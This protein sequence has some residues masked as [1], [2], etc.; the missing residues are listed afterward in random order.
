L[1]SYLETALFRD[2]TFGDS[3][4]WLRFT[5]R[6]ERF[7]AWLLADV[8]VVLEQV[9]AASKRGLYVTGFLTFE[10]GA[11][12][13]R[14]YPGS[15]A[16]EQGLP[17]CRFDVFRQCTSLDTREVLQASE[18]ESEIG[19]LIGGNQSG[20]SGTASGWSPVLARS[21]YLA[22]VRQIR[23]EIAV[24]SV[25]QV[26]LTFPGTG[27]EC[28]LVE[29]FGRLEHRQSAPYAAVIDH[30]DVQICSASPE[31][32]FTL[33]GDRIRCRPMK[34]TARRVPD[35]P[36]AD[37][38]AAEHLRINEKDRAENLMIVDMV[39]NDLGRIARRGSVTVDE[40][41]QIESFPTVH[42]M[43]T[44]VSAETDS[45]LVEI[46][47]AL[48]PS[49]S[50][51]G[52]PK[53]T[54]LDAI[55][56]L[57]RA[58]R[59]IYTGALGFVLPGR[60]AQFNVAIRTAFRRSP[61]E[62]WRYDVGSGV[63]WDSVPER[64]YQECLTKALVLAPQGTSD[65][66]KSGAEKSDAEKSDGGRHGEWN[67]DEPCGESFSLLESLSFDGNEYWL[68][69]RHLA[70]LEGAASRFG[71]DLHL[72]EVQDA[73]DRQARR[74][75]HKR[76]E[77]QAGCFKVRLLVARDGSVTLE[78]S[79]ARS[80]ALTPDDEGLVW[81]VPIAERPTDGDTVCDRP[82]L[83]NKTTR[84]AVYVQ[85]LAAARARYPDCDD[86]LLYDR[87]GELTESCFANLVVELDGKLVTPPWKSGFLAGTFRASLLE[88]GILQESPLFLSDLVAK[89]GGPSHRVS[90]PRIF[91]I[92]SVRGFIPVELLD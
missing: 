53:S 46:F 40:L 21:D 43:T 80:P 3:A 64:E 60:R 85:H 38:A 25:Y 84:R 61:V 44:S 71:F 62:A 57:E 1:N 36:V 16:G 17:Y 11:A 56:R 50:I 75:R 73:L 42:Q 27:P 39:R 70:R 29:L 52:A 59:S 54:A 28:S 26:N 22:S 82:F 48:F 20:S 66:E 81:K 49:A 45:S 74:L 23:Q 14:S 87:A 15:P 68:L 35:D 58:E 72:E 47:T 10:A 88:Q 2:S 86:V 69:E 24:G 13:D 4:R 33:E 67:T 18:V 65:T 77:G 76:Q 31:L 90:R 41:W 91:L 92:N 34:G 12:F 79:P 30:S 5:D 19:C 37:R 32:F 9:E 7:E 78:S 55:K 51:T 89:A 83:D 6:V 8:P 63:V